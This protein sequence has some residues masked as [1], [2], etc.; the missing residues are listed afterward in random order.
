[1]TLTDTVALFFE[2]Y[3]KSHAVLTTQHDPLWPS[4]CEVGQPYTD[5]DGQS[6]IAWQPVKR[7]L[8]GD[9]FAGLENALEMPIH[10]DV[11]IHYGTFWSANLEAEAPSGHVSLLY[12]WSPADAERLI[13]NLIGHAVA[14]RQNRTPFSVFFAC[15]EPDS[16]LFLTINNTTGEVQLEAPGKAPL[17][18][19]SDSLQTFM[20]QLVPA[21]HL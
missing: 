8:G 19:V 4:P 7:H 14:C 15:T 20:N 10:R 16:D 5:T 11:K 3:Q 17:R 18:V 6:I 1:M 9:D 12:L 13:E 2:H 21:P